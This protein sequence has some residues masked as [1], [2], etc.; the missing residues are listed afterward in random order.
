MS[1][2]AAACPTT[3]AQSNILQVSITTTNSETATM[4]VPMN[5]ATTDKS[6]ASSAT[7]QTAQNANSTSTQSVASTSHTEKTEQEKEAERLYEERMEEEYA[8]REGG[9]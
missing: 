5:S 3:H 8:K 7:A 1:A 2:C 9:A 4:P 6:T